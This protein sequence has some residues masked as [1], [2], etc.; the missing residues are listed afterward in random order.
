[1][2]LRKLTLQN[3]RNHKDSTLDFDKANFIIV[4]GAN[5]SGKTSVGQALS[6]NLTTTT[7]GLGAI[8]QGYERKITKGERQAI[9]TA[10]IQGQ[11][12][13]EN[14]V[15]LSLNG[16]GRTQQVKCLDA[17]SDKKTVNGFE[18]FLS[19]YKD[20]LGIALNTDAFATLDNKGQKDLLA[21][22]VL[23][24]RYD[25][26]EDT[27]LA[28]HEVI[29]ANQVNFD[30]E[31]FAVIEKAYKLLY[32]ERETVNRQVKEFVIPDALPTVT[33]VDSE[34]LQKELTEI[35][36]Q[37]T[38]LQADRDAAVTRAN[39]I[40]VTRARLQTKIDGL[41][42]E[43]SKGGDR[44]KELE[45]KIITPEKVK[46]LQATVARASEVAALR[47]QLSAWEG[48][49][50]V[51]KEQIEHLR[52]I[53][54]KGLND[55]KCPTCDQVIDTGK[56]DAMIVGLG[57]DETDAVGK[58]TELKDKIKAIGDVEAASAQLKDYEAAAKEKI[59]LEATL[60][61][62]VKTGKDTRAELNKLA[63]KQDAT[64][65]FNDPLGTLQARGEKVV[66]QLRPVIA[67]EERARD[68]ET[69]TKQRSELEKK[70]AKLQELVVYFDK[71]GVK[72]T[73]IAQYIGGFQNK[74]N[75]VLSAWGYSTSLS[76]DLSNF[77]VTTPRG[78][79]GPVK[80]LSGAEGHIFKAAFQCAV[81]S[82]ANIG[83]VVVDEIEELG[84]DIRQPLYMAIYQL[85]QQGA[86]EQAILI[87][88]STD[89]TVPNPQAPGSKYF[90]VENGTVEVLA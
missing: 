68:I 74:L 67:A 63:D 78:Y 56:I 22:L 44:L 32:K 65:P 31:P 10:E 3:Y 64:L 40:E 38:K 49:I 62:T 27:Q 13:L 41:L 5:A 75:T 45:T 15:T 70:A 33:G 71:D 73:L 55:T 28:V 88:Y 30:E 66:E 89:K 6:L 69:K 72:K 59:A 24:A 11:H 29:G 77:D 46:A 8:G 82:L 20:A 87:G 51:A 34:S 23:P 57:K 50:G 53:L 86:L 60:T 18:N 48:G 17:P 36:G 52:R 76:F 58:A 54:E 79:V 7:M 9:I 80:E 19:R 47:K 90:F 35:K 16:S 12:I 14:I 26:P 2:R 43:V 21:K 85:I 81:S 39:E 37:R 84:E 25:F 4:R 61:G 42:A 83:L 1:M